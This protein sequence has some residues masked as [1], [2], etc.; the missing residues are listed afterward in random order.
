MDCS[1][2][3]D[4]SVFSERL[5]EL[6]FE[7]DLNQSELAEKIGVKSSTISR[8]LSGQ[9]IPEVEILV[10]LAD[11]FNCTV[12]FLIGRSET[13]PQGAKY[14]KCPKFS[15]QLEKII[16]NSKKSKY[17]IQK[18]TEIPKTVMYYWQTGKYQPSID[19]I[20]KLANYFENTVDY[21]IGRIEF[22]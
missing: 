19:N 22:D 2:V 1:F 9:K 6:M 12:D 5:Q 17:R 20:I 13:F 10:R 16:L 15:Q 8:Y 4:E 21:I 11:Y 3:F 7:K 18:D 14:L